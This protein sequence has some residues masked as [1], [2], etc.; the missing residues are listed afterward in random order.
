MNTALFYVAH[1]TEDFGLIC[2]DL[3]TVLCSD[4]PYI[5]S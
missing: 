5:E 3:Q 4:I 2:T 1:L